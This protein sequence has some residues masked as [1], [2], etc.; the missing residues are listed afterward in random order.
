MRVVDA[1]G[2]VCPKP[3]ILTKQAIDSGEKEIEVLVD[4]DVSFQNVK[5]F[6][7]S[8]GYS[9]IEDI[10]QDDGDVY[11]RQAYDSRTSCRCVRYTKFIQLFFDSLRSPKFLARPFRIHMKLSLIHI[12]RCEVQAMLLRHPCE[13]RNLQ[14]HPGLTQSF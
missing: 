14:A 10:K 4:N 11:K 7:K 5:R 1:R 3:V 2:L 12:F 9:V 6:L 13:E 8:R